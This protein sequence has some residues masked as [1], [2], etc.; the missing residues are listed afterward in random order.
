MLYVFKARNDYLA[1]RQL[2]QFAVFRQTIC[3]N[4][5]LEICHT[6]LATKLVCEYLTYN[7]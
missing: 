1:A 5:K 7:A 4:S 6:L 2:L 3:G